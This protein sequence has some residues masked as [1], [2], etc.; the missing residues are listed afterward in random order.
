MKNKKEP[1]IKKGSEYAADSSS[2]I[3]IKHCY[4][5]NTSDTS[6]SSPHR[7]K[8]KRS[9]KEKL[10]GEFKKIKALFFKVN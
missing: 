8:S 2:S 5:D 9:S 1:E 6:S 7:K 4:S 10:K 3:D